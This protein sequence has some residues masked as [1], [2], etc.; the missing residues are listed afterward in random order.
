MCK[1]SVMVETLNETLLW[2]VFVSESCV[3]DG[4]TGKKGYLRDGQVVH[5]V[6]VLIQRFVEAKSPWATW[7]LFK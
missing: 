1:E 5:V 7:L 3:S 6:R 4:E 2:R